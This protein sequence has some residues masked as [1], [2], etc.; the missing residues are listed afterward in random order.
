MQFSL[1]SMLSQSMSFMP[2]A[3]TMGDWVG[4]I[5]LRMVRI[6]ASGLNS[7]IVQ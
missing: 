4:A 2:L 3:I 7:M 5:I 6:G 1:I